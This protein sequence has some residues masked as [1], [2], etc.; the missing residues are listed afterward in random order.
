MNSYCDY[1]RSTFVVVSREASQWRES[2]NVGAGREKHV[3]F[4][5]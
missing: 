2:F 5:P 3:P 1:N 4:I